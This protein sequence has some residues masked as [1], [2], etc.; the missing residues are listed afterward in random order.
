MQHNCSFFPSG[1]CLCFFSF[2]FLFFIFSLFSFFHFFSFG[3]IS[4]PGSTT[5]WILKSVDTNLVKKE[6]DK[7][8]C[9][10]KGW[11]ILF[12]CFAFF[13]SKGEA[14][15]EVWTLSISP[16][17]YCNLIQEVWAFKSR[18]HAWNMG[19]QLGPRTMHQGPGYKRVASDLG[20]V[21]NKLVVLG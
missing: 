3:L 8:I 11:S 6:S 18:N 16:S 9:I 12:C 14:H 5:I 1:I 17:P 2:L 21:F 10:Q 20:I 15:F 7:F 13:D 4:S 19:A